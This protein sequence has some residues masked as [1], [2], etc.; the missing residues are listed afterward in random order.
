MDE[1]TLSLV[2]ISILAIVF[3]VFFID[4][5]EK[6]VL[7]SQE[8]QYHREALDFAIQ[9]NE[10]ILGDGYLEE[11]KIRGFTIETYGVQII[12]Y[13]RQTN[14]SFGVIEGRAVSIPTLIL[15]DENTYKARLVVWYE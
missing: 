9:L 8:V 12:D 13:D 1:E 11:E 10:E 7:I 5:V 4:V 14:W 6:H 2:F 3:V 15:S